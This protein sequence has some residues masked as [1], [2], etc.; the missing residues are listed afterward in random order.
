MVKKSQSHNWGT[1]IFLK[2]LY[3]LVIKLESKFSL[4]KD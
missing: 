3:C 2:N 1:E 4:I